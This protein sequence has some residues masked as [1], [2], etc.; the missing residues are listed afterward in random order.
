[1]IAHTDP[2]TS[3]KILFAETASDVLDLVRRAKTCQAHVIIS[4]VGLDI[5]VTKKAIRDALS[6]FE[7]A[8]ECGGILWLDDLT[9]RLDRAL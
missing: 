4:N 2:D 3:A 5:A 7:P 8:D 6:D 9:F 1:M